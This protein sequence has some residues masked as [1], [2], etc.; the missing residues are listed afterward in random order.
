MASANGTQAG[1]PT[2]VQVQPSEALEESNSPRKGVAFWFIFLSINI[3][4]FLSA[5]ELTAVSTALPTI[6][7]DLN[8]TDFVWVGSAYTLSSTAF[9]P[10]TG[11]FSQI[12]GRKPAVF[13]CLALF[14]IGS[15]ICGAATNMSM[16]IAARAIQGSGGGGLQAV[17]SIILADLVTLRERGFYSAFFSL[18]W[19]LASTIGP[20]VAGSLVSRGQWRWLF[21]LNLPIIG[22]ASVLVL[23]FLQLPVPQGSFHEKVSRLDWFGNLII[24]GSTAAC[25][26]AINWGG[27]VAPWGA[28]RVLVPLI[29]GLVG[30]CFFML[31]ES[32][33][34]KEPLVPYSLITNRTSLSG[35]L[36][37]FFMGF[38][39]LGLIYFY[40]V[41][42]QA[43]KG[44]SAAESGVIGLSLAV[45][46][47][48]AVC[49]GLSVKIT[50]RYRPQ[51]WVG[52]SLLVAGL[53]LLSTLKAHDSI[54]K[55]AGYLI[56]A[57][58]G[59]G[60]VYAGGMF[61]ILAPL[62]VT[63]NAHA[64]AFM[65][66][67]RSFAGV[68]G[69]TVGSTVLQNE[70]TSKLPPDFLNRFPQGVQI[71]YAAIP[72]IPSLPEP[73]K[74]EVQNLFARALSDIWLVLLGISAAGLLC[75]LLM[76]GLPLHGNMDKEFSGNEKEVNNNDYSGKIVMKPDLKADEK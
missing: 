12:F 70:L 8:G 18:T 7:H 52:W 6:A 10:M 22:V 41:F 1:E 54:G 55:G 34:A 2:T 57:S 75:S 53:G 37:T 47:V 49:V 66:F 29:V 25:T 71:A 65:T 5:M 3:T 32:F 17:S 31:Y 63:S 56:F 74:T 76:K 20:V 33:I 67:L 43:C 62:P 27:V 50:K 9:L 38:I 69:I 15:A 44:V 59:L 35:Y 46:T 61:P 68:W 26:I 24:I 48:F 60:C 14:F 40:P 4:L 28:A 42:F 51:I 36:Q 19:S 45:S 21:Y 30:L 23:I 72:V 13:L 58:V 64:L 73:V 16:L 39:T 11:G